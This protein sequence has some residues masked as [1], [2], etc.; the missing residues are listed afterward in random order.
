MNIDWLKFKELTVSNKL[1][2]KY[3]ENETYYYISGY[4][5]TTLITSCD[6]LKIHEDCIDFEINYK[7]LANKPIVSSTTVQ[8]IAPIGAKTITVNG[9]VKKLFARNIG[10]QFELIQGENELAYTMIFPW[11]KIVGVEVI[12]CEA[13]DT[14]SMKVYDT[15][16]GLYSG[17]PSLMLNQ[18]SFDLNLPDDFYSRMAQFDADAYA[19][20]VIKFFYNSKSAKTIGIN[21]IVNEVKS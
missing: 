21:L 6:L 2:L 19:G 20:L 4:D 18:F 15:E 17:V 7:D 12:N 14:I 16:S 11:A 8:S 5:G 13:L 1:T 9:V 3:L 10:L